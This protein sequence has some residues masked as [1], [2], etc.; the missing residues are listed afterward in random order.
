MNILIDIGFDKDN[1]RKSKENESLEHRE[2]LEQLS[3]K[4]DQLVI[5]LNKVFSI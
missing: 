3:D 1:G 5:V 4:I 2:P